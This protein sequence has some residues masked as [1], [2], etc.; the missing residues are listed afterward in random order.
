MIQEMILYCGVKHFGFSL[1]ALTKSYLGVH[2]AK[3]VRLEF[4]RIGSN[5]F[6]RRQVKYGANDIVYPVLIHRIQ[7]KKLRDENLLVCQRLENNFLKVIA[8]MEFHGMLVDVPRWLEIYEKTKI[9]MAEAL[10]KLDN[11]LITN[12]AIPFIGTLNMFTGK[13]DIKVN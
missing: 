2:L 1:Q 8:E 5:P 9:K 10:E 12:R 11:Y 4:T 13:P 6:N 3:D 7:M